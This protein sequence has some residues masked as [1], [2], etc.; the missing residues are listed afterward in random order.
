MV[1]K[2]SPW[3]D[4]SETNCSNPGILW[5]ARL[6]RSWTPVCPVVGQLLWLNF[7]L[8][9]CK[10][11]QNWISIRNQWFLIGETLLSSLQFLQ[12][13]PSSRTL[14]KGFLSW[15]GAIQGHLLRLVRYFQTCR[16]TR[17]TWTVKWGSWTPS[18]TTNCLVDCVFVKPHFFTMIPDSKK[19]KQKNWA[20]YQTWSVAPD[21]PPTKALR[22][23]FLVWHSTSFKNPLSFSEDVTALYKSLL[24]SFLLPSSSAMSRGL[25]ENQS[26][27]I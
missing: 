19:L 14:L 27:W 5:S 16:F 18:R 24:S 25:P 2:E 7:S 21:P 13:T 4:W 3:P 20:V 11:N 26:S 15:H 17:F 6:S 12:A 10:R 8:H 9:F 1:A 22:T 23:S